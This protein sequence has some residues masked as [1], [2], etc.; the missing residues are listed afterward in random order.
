MDVDEEDT[1]R[2]PKKLKTEEPGNIVQNEKDKRKRKTV[3]VKGPSFKILEYTFNSV[4]KEVVNRYKSKVELLDSYKD[5]GEKD[6]DEKLKLCDKVR[7]FLVQDTSLL[8]VRDQVKGMLNLAIITGNK[9]AEMR[10]DQKKVPKTDVILLYKD[11]GDIIYTDLIQ[12]TL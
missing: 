2:T 1:T 8:I 5:A 6:F 9:A 3:K 11:I 7:K 12:A 4:P 10:V